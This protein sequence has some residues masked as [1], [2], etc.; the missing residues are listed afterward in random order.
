MTVNWTAPND[1]GSAITDYDLQY[2]EQNVE[3]WTDANVGNVLTTDLTGLKPGVIYEVQVRAENVGGE[4]QWSGTAT[5]PQLPALGAVTNFRATPGNRASGGN[6]DRAGG[7]RPTTGIEYLHLRGLCRP[8]PKSRSVGSMLSWT[9]T[10]SH[11]RH[12]LLRAG[13]A[14]RQRRPRDLLPWC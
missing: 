7:C 13:H 6:R 10:R 11:Q 5:A 4:S 2:R 8:T 12:D 14:Q 3:Q 1:N 9:I